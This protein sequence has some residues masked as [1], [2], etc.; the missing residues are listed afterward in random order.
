ML[1]GFP[2]KEQDTQKTYDMFGVP[3]VDGQEYDD[4][5]MGESSAPDQG[6]PVD[7][8]PA[9]NQPQNNDEVRYQ[10]WQQQHDLLKNQYEQ[11]RKQNEELNQKMSAF[12]Q[13][14]KKE[15]EAP[16]EVF[17]EPPAAP[18]KPY[19][20]SM[21]EAMSDPNSESAR[22]LVGISEHN[23]L[24][25]QYNYLHQQWMD[26]KHQKAID[27]LYARE[28]Q[29]DAEITR[30]AEVSQSINQVIAATQQKYGIDYDTALD[31]VNTM[32]DDSSITI[33]NLFEL[34]KMKKGY[35]PAP[36]RNQDG[37]Y[38]PARNP[39]QQFNPF[40]AQVMNAPPPDFQQMQ[41]AQ[42]VPPTMGVHNAQG[43][44]YVDPFIAQIQETIRMS[45]KQNQF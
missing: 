33:D 9:S 8:Q 28:D 18:Q 11:V 43:T 31:F 15:E 17:P 41:R 6:Q 25:N 38:A 20:F 23:N 44:Q 12:E 22:Y 1:Q 45:N 24:M 7:Q 30:K 19:G 34:Y 10:Y 2:Q 3:V 35:A 4:S 40:G 26:S 39:G 5:W 42:S 13:S 14:Q 29:K 21:Q 37:R 27:K 36:V 32:S 16:E